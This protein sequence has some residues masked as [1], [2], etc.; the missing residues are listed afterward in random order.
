MEQ[1]NLFWKR[2]FRRIQPTDKFER[3]MAK[4]QTS[5]EENSNDIFMAKE[6]D[7]ERLTELVNSNE[8]K[9]KKKLYT[10]KKYKDTD[11]CKIMRQYEKLANDENIKLYYSTK[12]STILQ[13]YLNFKSNPESLN[14]SNLSITEISD[15]IDKLKLFEQSKEYRNYTQYHDSLTVREL[16]ELQKKIS[17][18]IFQQANSFWANPNRWETT[19]EYRMEQRLKELSGEKTE[20]K[21]HSN[22]AIFFNKYSTIS[23][24][25]IEKFNWRTLETS[26]W[27]SGFHSN[28]AL[29]VG[30]YSFTNEWQGNNSGRNVAIDENGLTL[31]TVNLPANSLAWDIQKGFVKRSYNY[32]ADVIQTSATFRQRYGIFSAKIRCSGKVNHA[33]W[34]RGNK[35]LPHINIFHFNGDNI[36]VGNANQHKLDGITIN[37]ISNEQYYIYTLEWTPT[38]LIWYINNVEIYRTNEN[39][40][41]DSLY[42]GLNSFLPKRKEPSTGKFEVEWIKVYKCK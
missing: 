27:S 37:G 9:E 13:E 22:S 15:R 12:E 18:P 4:I 26:R 1:L 39:I 5:V 36:C 20:A 16:E 23:E 34:L 14:L 42:L 25:F 38:T 29:L 21:K 35:K 40:P 28:N 19:S 7:K 6:P 24:S 11:E 32:T 8:F 2:L 31:H 17:E 30:N 10:T 41:H 33:F 3:K